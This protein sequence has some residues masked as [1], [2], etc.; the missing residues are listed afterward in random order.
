VEDGDDSDPDERRHDPHHLG[1]D[2][3]ARSFE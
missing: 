3:F 1:E 2:K